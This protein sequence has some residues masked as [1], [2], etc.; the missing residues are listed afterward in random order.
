MKNCG[1]L[2]SM[3]H[4]FYSVAFKIQLPAK[5]CNMLKYLRV[6]NPKLEDN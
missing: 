1:L 3:A 4:G 6:F 5:V 2:L